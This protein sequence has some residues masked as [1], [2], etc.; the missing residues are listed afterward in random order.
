MSFFS[1]RDIA[2]PEPVERGAVAAELERV[3]YAVEGK[4][5]LREVS[6]R[7][8]AGEVLAV[9][10]P[11]GAGKST[12]LG[13]LAGDLRPESGRVLVAGKDLSDWSGIELARLRSVLP[14]Q[15]TVTFPFTVAEVVRMGRT[16]WEGTEAE[17]FDETEIAA[18][19]KATGM[20]EFA[21]RRFTTLSGGEQARAAL[22]RVLAQR[23]GVLLLDEPTAA[24]DLRHSEEILTLA[25]ARAEAG[26][27]VLVVLH[28]LGLAAAY[29]DR[30]AVLSEGELAAEGTPAE[31]LTESLLSEVYRHPVEVLIHPRTGKPIVLPHRAAEERR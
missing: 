25:T 24:L 21:E 2:L 29:A 27:A 26:D 6:L 3:S 19:L 30:V 16:P 28:D 14:Q 22:S 8:H 18:A 23:A 20:T 15:N 12:T 31:V 5:L 4:T 7:L 9:V 1:R 17:D 13:L 10:G 11:N